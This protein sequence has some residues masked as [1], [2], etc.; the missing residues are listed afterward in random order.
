MLCAEEEYLYKS[1]PNSS[2][3]NNLLVRKNTGK[4]DNV[5]WTDLIMLQMRTYLS[6]KWGGSK[7]FN[8]FERVDFIYMICQN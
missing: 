3:K 5:N 7:S 6:P 2:V 4:V 8:S 1:K